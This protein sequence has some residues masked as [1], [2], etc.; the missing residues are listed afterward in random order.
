MKPS[1]DNLRIR[2]L[3]ELASPASVAEELP[4]GDA[5]AA[6]ILQTRREIQAILQGRTDRLLVI[7]GPCSIHD[8]N[9]ALEYA[10]RLL[11]LREELQDQLLIVMRTYFE[12][13]RT[14]VGWKGLINDPD[15]DGSFHIN[16]GLRMARKLLLDLNAMGMP[17]GVEFL[18]LITPQYLVELVSWGAIGART[19]ESQSHRE[20][21]SGLSC[22]VGFKNGT[23]GDVKIAVDAARAA[24]HPHCFVGL[25]KPGHGAIF[26]TAGNEDTHIILRGGTNATNYDAS[27][28]AAACELLKA[29]G[30]REQV[31]VDFSHANCA[32][33]H[34]RQLE[35]GRDISAQIAGGSRPIFGVM[36]ESNLIEG[37]QD[38]VPGQRLVYGQ[39]IT[40][41]CLSWDD[42]VPLL[43]LLG[44]AV[45][46]RRPVSR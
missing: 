46:R 44:T 20:L 34:R 39:S 29:A 10:R 32:K 22:P 43:R 30:L 9:A 35:V 37:R 5:G 41:P 42:T 27:S 24:A 25:T 28:V 36:I 16:K 3:T 23:G 40:D 8:P 31:M 12:K 14:V 7:V 6:T 11:A 1:T 26:E 19:T 45:D 38:V 4:L 21:V 2:R 18:D 13:P 15:L 33:Q 17:T